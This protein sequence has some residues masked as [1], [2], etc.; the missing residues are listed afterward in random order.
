MITITKQE[1][2]KRLLAQNNIAILMHR[3]PDGDAIGCAYA[4]CMALRSL[5]K[6]AQP[7]CSDPI[8]AMYSYFTDY[9]PR[10]DFIPDYVVSVDLADT[11]LFGD[12][13][14]SYRERVDLC[15]DHHGSNTGFAAEGYI[16]ASAGACAQ[17]VADIIGYMGVDL[18]V[19]MAD[20]L[21]TGITTDTGC[22]RYTNADAACH[23]KAAY[24]IDSGARSGMIN[25]LMF[26]TKSRERLAL[27][28]QALETLTYYAGG[29]IALI[30][31][32]AEM[33]RS[34]GAAD[35]DTDGI[36]SIPRQIMG[37]KI[38]ITVKEKE[39]GVFKLSL[40]TTDDVDASAI[41]QTLGGGGHRAAAGCSV[42]GTLQQA[43]DAIVTAALAALE[44]QT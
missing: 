24:L 2:A 19:P 40:R 10:Q 11:Q 34:T 16:D 37:V 4:L 28:K 35:S 21:F 23:R 7:L 41:C 42:S 44:K 15:I 33:M 31:L 9:A 13:L 38:G 25:R 39:N 26:E 12:A 20:A 30:A 5:G 43:I 17:I 27:E 18:S 3:S 1:A 22:F 32:T 6:Q 8:P 29:Q 14:A 36:A